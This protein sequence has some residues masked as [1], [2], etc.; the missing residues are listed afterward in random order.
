MLYYGKIIM[1]TKKFVLTTF[2]VF[3]TFMLTA[4]TGLYDK[5]SNHAPSCVF[6]Q[7]DIPSQS[8]VPSQP[9]I[10]SRP[11]P[12]EH[13][14]TDPDLVHGVLPNGIRYVLLH[15]TTPEN[16]VSMHLNV[17]SGSM[18]ERDDQR[19]IAHYLEHMLFNGSTHFK[20]GEL[21]E[22]FQSIGMM[23]GADANAHTGFFETVYDILLPAGDK[24]SLEKGLLVLQDYAEGALLLESEVERERGVIL[25]EK[26]E[27]DS[28]SFRTF[29][30]SLE[31]ELPDSLI[32]KRLPIGS[33]SVIKTM[34]R[35]MP[36]K[37]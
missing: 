9:D 27:R 34:N 22:Y 26:R 23:F 32:A 6:S 10:S 36:L 8:D 25:A 29:K 12:E 17:Q 20:P 14:L 2:V 31:F 24:E 28:V 4:C 37:F 13:L 3:T 30:A 33:E 15:N 21:I 16:R 19:G 35:D 18:H 11:F 7:S 1:I 5:K